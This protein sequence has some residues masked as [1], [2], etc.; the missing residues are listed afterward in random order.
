LPLAF[1]DLDMAVVV[2]A[3]NYNTRGMHELT[4]KLITDYILPAAR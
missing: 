2:T 3:P 4:D 1:P